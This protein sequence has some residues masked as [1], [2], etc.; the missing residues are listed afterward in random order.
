MNIQNPGN[1][2]II[3]FAD[4]HSHLLCYSDDG[5]VNE[6]IMCK[7][8]ESAYLDGARYIC[9][10]PH[11]HPGYFGDNIKKSEEAFELLSRYAAE[12]YPDL[13]LAL[14]NELHYERGCDSWLADRRCRTMN[15]T[16]YVLIDFHEREEKYNIINGLDSLLRAGYIPILAHAERYSEVGGDLN[17]LI[18]YKQSGVL[19]QVNAGSLFKRFGIKA[20]YSAKKIIK[21]GIADFISSD[22]HNI[23]DRAPGI[24]EAY[25]Y[26]QSRCGGRYADAICS[27]N[28]VELIFGK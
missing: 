8:L 4:I 15:G 6:E 1:G 5:A 7:M 22:A 17:F 9:A 2:G 19:I 16:K 13:T 24:K 26:V 12:H 14:G 21:N 25:D 10:T 27:G 18:K 11:F 3:I 23:S 20:Y 28:A